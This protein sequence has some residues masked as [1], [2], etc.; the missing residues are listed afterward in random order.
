M[1]VVWNNLMISLILLTE[2]Q[3]QD[4]PKIQPFN[5]PK[6]VI[7]N[8]KVS[9]TCTAMSGPPPLEFSWLKDGKEIHTKDNLSIQTYKD[10]SVL[11][12]ERVDVQSAGNYT[13]T[14]SASS[15]VDRYTASLEIRAPPK[16][17]KEPEDKDIKVGSTLILECEA[18]GLPS[19]DVSWMK[20]DGESRN[21]FKFI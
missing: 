10:Y 13:C 11:L 8:Q 17:I 3:L 20:L 21:G 14:L 7:L 1:N 2:V 6:Q 19:P 5:F 16:W 15:G 9:T 18:T 12:I 4:L